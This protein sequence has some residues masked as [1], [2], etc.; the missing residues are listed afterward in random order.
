MYGFRKFY[1][2]AFCVVRKHCFALVL[3]I[4]AC[5]IWQS[6]S[7]DFS[8]P[9]NNNPPLQVN[10]AQVFPS[11]S[12]PK[13]LLVHSYHMEYEWVAGISRGV[14]RAL[15]LSDVELELFHMDTKRKTD[16]SWKI[17]SGEIAK[18][19]VADWQPDVVIAVDDN[20]QKYFASSYLG[21]TKP[22]IVFCGVNAE[23]EK[24]G[25]PADNITGM[26]E[27]PHMVSSLQL[28][29]SIVPEAHRIAVITDNS[30]T[31]EGTLNYLKSLQTGFEMVSWETPSTFDSWRAAVL[32]AQDTA[33]AI[34]IYTYHT[35]KQE[36]SAESLSPKVVMDWSVANSKIPLVALLSF[37]IEDGLL[38]GVVESA[39]E[40]GYEAGKIALSLLNGECA[41]NIPVKT[42]EK[43]QAMLNLN[44]ARR[45]GLDVPSSVIES[46]DI[47]IGALDDE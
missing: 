8:N 38:C 22:K 41:G 39:M 2:G 40:H 15:Q 5:F 32:R 34:V 24:Y 17:E 36:G 35:V 4:L 43:G 37:G 42:A 25:Y 18:K 13:V 30:L 19:T 45:L 9:S 6:C 29:K 10:H 3:A 31:S 20:A 11:S 7:K 46:A 16:E 14:K 12:T 21:K 47:I 23:L 27:R 1:T 28:L 33:D 44:T 26:L